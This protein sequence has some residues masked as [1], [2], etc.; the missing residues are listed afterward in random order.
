[1]IKLNN[2]YDLVIGVDTSKD[3]FDAA[4]GSEGERIRR[5]RNGKQIDKFV[6]RVGAIEGKVLVVLEATGGL[7]RRIARALERAGITFA[8]VNPR[9]IRDF[10][11]ATGQLAKTDPID[12]G[13]IALFGERLDVRLTQLP[14]ETEQKLQTL[15]RRRADLTE[16]IAAEKN[17]SKGAEE[18]EAAKMVERHLRWLE[19]DRDKLDQKIDKLIAGDENLSNKREV[20]KSMKGV[21]DVTS[22]VLVSELPE[23]GKLNRKQIAKLVGV[24]PLD[25]I[26]GKMGGR[27]HIWGGRKSVRNALYMSTLVAV[28][29]NPALK[30]FYQ[31]LIGN[32][33]VKKVAL[34]A[35]MRKMLTILNA[36]VRDNK[37]FSTIAA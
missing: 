3:W 36:M 5:K 29:Y 14:S 4:F 17:R 30:E 13:I 35:A 22:A 26:S 31:R 10:A 28:R 19:K 25:D 33:K 24:A 6:K 11:K 12:A 23:L 15:V 1:M 21:A 2:Q 16:M 9:Q 8:I 37:M 7:E 20:L 32:G 18:D 34:V 27:A